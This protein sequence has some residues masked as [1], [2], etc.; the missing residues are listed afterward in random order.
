MIEEKLQEPNIWQD[1]ERIQSLNQQLVSLK[2]REKKL[3]KI[4]RELKENTLE[5][6][7]KIEKEIEEMERIS[8][9]KGEYD[10]NNAFMTLHAGTGG[11]DAC[12]WVS[13]LLRMYLKFFE[14]KGWQAKMIDHSPH[15]EAGY[16]SVTLEIKGDYVYGFL[17]G[18]TGVHRLVRISPFDA[19]KMRHTSFA[20]VEILPE[21]EENTK[22]QIKDE[23]LKTETFLA[24]GHGGQNVQKTQ[25]AVRVT[26][27]PTGLSVSSQSERSQSQNKRQAFKIL[28][29]KLLMLS[30]GQ[31]AKEKAKIK[32]PVKSIS[33]GNQIRSY[34]FHPYQLVKDLRTG[35][36][37][38]DLEKVLDGNLEPFINSY[39][40]LQLI[41]LR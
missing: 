22:I 27:L 8:L 15:Q 4:G 21:F 39:I 37:T 1:Y 38:S 34:V 11:V 6:P 40:N 14:K 30:E 3:E 26:H 7:D 31:R 36:E 19:E 9:L 23:D 13:I 28:Q 32:G 20:S 18:E 2:K 41:P 10:K 25:T 33:W 17:K 24:S 16:K 5:D 35:Y 12:D 29:A